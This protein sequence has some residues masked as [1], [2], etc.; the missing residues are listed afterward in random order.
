[1]SK[2]LK[3]LFFSA[4]LF[5]LLFF[6]TS[7]FASFPFDSDKYLPPPTSVNVQFN[8]LDL[9]KYY[10]VSVSGIWDAISYKLAL[11]ISDSGSF[12]KT[13]PV[14]NKRHATDKFVGG[15]TPE[16]GVF[17]LSGTYKK[18]HIIG[19]WTYELSVPPREG[20]KFPETYNGS[21]TFYTTQPISESSGAGIIAGSLTLNKTDWKDN[22]MID[23]VAFSQTD[24]FLNTW[25][26]VSTCKEVL[27]GCFDYQDAVDSQARFNTLTGEVGYAHCNKDERTQEWIPA[28]PKTKLMVDDHISTGAESSAILQFKDM[29]TFQMKPDT[30][31][32]VKS[33][34]EQETKLGLV[35][36]HLWINFKKMLTNGTMEVEMGQAVAGIKGTT[37]VVEQINGVSSLKVIEGIVSFKSKQTNQ[38]IDVNAGEKVSA[39]FNGLSTVEKFD[40]AAES[41]GWKNLDEIEKSNDSSGSISPVIIIAT[42]LVVG[43]LG[44]VVIKKKK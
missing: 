8:N 9:E 10:V 44:F 14:D 13:I 6:V 30:E 3:L 18:G 24:N 12:S 32:I 2:V 15:V 31:V 42:V 43:S 21:G 26:A 39:D 25:T 33:P 19:E 37:L 38:T 16:D 5:C 34:P 1:M 20:W 35:S 41:A 29:T 36:G 22:K 23:H 27:C 11:N 4:W 28:T 17:T 40:V 7:S